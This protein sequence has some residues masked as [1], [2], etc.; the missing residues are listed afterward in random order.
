MARR[1]APEHPPRPMT[2]P[3]FHK[4]LDLISH[5][6]SRYE[7]FRNFIEA[8]YCALARRT[9]LSRARSDALE[10]G[11]MQVIRRYSREKEAPQRLAELFSRLVVALSAY[12]GDFLG[13]A[14]MTAEFGNKYAGQFFTPY[15]ISSLL[16][17]MNI[18]REC[19]ET[20][21]AEGHPLRLLEP[22]SGAG[23]MAVAMADYLQEEGF[24]LSKAL[25]ATLVD[26]DPL[27]MQMGFLQVSCKDIPAVCV[28]GDSLSLDEYSFA[29]TLAGA[30]ARGLPIWGIQELPPEGF[31]IAHPPLLTLPASRTQTPAG[32]VTPEVILITEPLRTLDEPSAPRRRASRAPH[33]IASNPVESPTP[34]DAQLEMF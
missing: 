33:E 8:A 18:S 23:C 2:I 34:A 12:H 3:E 1:V 13:E 15:C 28:H 21:L 29:F 11:Y 9:A 22:A 19:I 27:C 25:F 30:R 7:N 26:V 4:A 31:A 5:S 24:T 14:Y 6:H 17:R 20:A 16:A 10:E 32:A